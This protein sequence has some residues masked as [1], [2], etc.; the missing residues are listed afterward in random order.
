MDFLQI[1]IKKAAKCA[2]MKVLLAY[3]P[4]CKRKWGAY[5]AARVRNVFLI[6]AQIWYNCGEQRR[7][8]GANIEGGFMK[9]VLALALALVLALVRISQWPRKKSP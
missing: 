1:L 8:S 5:A 3:L 4:V 2:G 6:L 7:P 9:K